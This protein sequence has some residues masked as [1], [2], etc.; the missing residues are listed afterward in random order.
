MLKVLES[1]T[2]DYL[3]KVL[4]FLILFISFLAL[5]YGT[6]DTAELV[7]SSLTFRECLISGMST[8][9]GMERFGFTPHLISIFLWSIFKD[10]NA[11]ISA[12]SFLNFV[13]YCI[14]IY[15]FFSQIRNN[16]FIKLSILI[17]SPIPAYAVYSYSEMSYIFLIFVVILSLKKNNYLISSLLAILLSAYKETSILLIFPII[18]AGLFY[19]NLKFNLRK[20]LV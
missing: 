13:L 10:I 9:S 14:I 5:P 11:T 7:S 17:F 20:I 18:F 4:I 19:E 6:G 2:A 12:W 8:C 3:T 1:K 15:Y 16:K